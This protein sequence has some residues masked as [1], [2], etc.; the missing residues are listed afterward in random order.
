MALPLLPWQ[1]GT[2]GSGGVGMGDMALMNEYKRTGLTPYLG[3]TVELT[4]MAWVPEIW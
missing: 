3:S 2:A 1:H 4:L